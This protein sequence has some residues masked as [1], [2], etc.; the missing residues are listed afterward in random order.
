MLHV[1]GEATGATGKV[2]KR[3]RNALRGFAIPPQVHT[4]CQF[5][6]RLPPTDVHTSVRPMSFGIDRGERRLLLSA[7]LHLP[8][9]SVCSP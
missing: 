2:V 8:R 9:L 1:F 3:V 4:D 7:K 5:L 6:Y